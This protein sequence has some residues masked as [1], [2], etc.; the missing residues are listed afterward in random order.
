[1]GRLTLNSGGGGFK[2]RQGPHISIGLLFNGYLG[3][4]EAIS[5]LHSGRS[6]KMNTH[7]LLVHR[8]RMRRTTFPAPIRLHV[9]EF[10]YVQ[11][12]F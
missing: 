8:L 1:V 12:Y 11:G 9:V 2:Y 3:C 7:F 4:S 6:L 5:Q 10:N